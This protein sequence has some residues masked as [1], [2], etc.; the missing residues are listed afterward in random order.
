VSELNLRSELL[1]DLDA[2]IT[3]RQD[4]GHTA[5]GRRRVY[6]ISGGKFSG[7]QL[8][9]ELLPGGADWIMRGTGGTSEI[10]VRATLATDDG[11]LIYMHYRGIYHVRLEVK[12]RL[13]RGDDVSPSEYYFRTT[14]RFETGSE[15]YGW[16][17]HTLA[18]G[19][20]TVTETGIAYRIHQVL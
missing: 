13:D 10:D 5:F 19:V 17:N 14:P 12:E 8:R 18:V 4:V 1:F 9:G 20:G 15:R 7:P 16:L 11:D 3:S 6:Y 2:T